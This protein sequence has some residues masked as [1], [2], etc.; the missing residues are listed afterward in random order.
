MV[1]L[2]LTGKPWKR[3]RS[4]L[5]C[6]TRRSSR[7]SALRGTRRRRTRSRRG[8][9][10]MGSL[11]DRLDDA[12]PTTHV[13]LGSDGGE[14]TG[15]RSDAPITDWDDALRRLGVDPGAFQIVDD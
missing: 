1:C 8:G 11:A 13:D 6:R 14:F 15:L 9:K 10:L 2:R 5:N 4:T 3:L 7:P 12:R